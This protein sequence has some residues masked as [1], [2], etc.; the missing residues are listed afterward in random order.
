MSSGFHRRQV[1][2]SREVVC[3]FKATRTA[4]LFA[5]T[6]LVSQNNRERPPSKKKHCN[7]LRLI[8]K[9]AGIFTKLYQLAYGPYE[10]QSPGPGFQLK[11]PIPA[12]E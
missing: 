3:A 2:P 6:S 7:S 4:Y 12:F 8:T 11:Q 1:R 10:Y 5:L 9:Q